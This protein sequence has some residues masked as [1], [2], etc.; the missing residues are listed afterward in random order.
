MYWCYVV[1]VI[2]ASSWCVYCILQIV[3]SVTVCQRL[4]IVVIAECGNRCVRG[5]GPLFESVLLTTVHMLYIHQ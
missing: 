2:C 1:L 4:F 3:Q 5:D